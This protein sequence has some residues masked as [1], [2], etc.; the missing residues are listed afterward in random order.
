VADQ[1]DINGTVQDVATATIPV[2]DHG[3]LFGDSVYETLRAYERRFFRWDAHV[4]RLHASAGALELAVPV[5]ADELKARAER[6]MAAADVGNAAVRIVVTRGVGPMDIDPS[7]C[8]RPNVLVF[9]RPRP[10]FAPG[11]YETGM[12]L[13]VVA[14]RRNPRKSLDPNV[15]SGNYLNSVLALVE[16]RRAGAYESVMLNVEGHVTEGSTSNVFAV[17]DGVVLTSPVDSGLLGGITRMTL[18]Q[19]C[20][21]EGIP[22]EERPLLPEELATADELFITSTLK[23]V[24]PV[25]RLDG[26][27]VGDGRAGA[28]TRRLLAAYR[29]AVEKETGVT[30]ESE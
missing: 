11:A 15:K 17:R 12:A 24:M 27:A 22:A 19:L 23:Q 2:M 6:A 20:G 18:L 14:R 8:D 13:Q 29:A 7:G 1:V 4:R 28:I 16:A 25:T 3:F 21:Q 5:E 26:R 10:R 9:A 30:P